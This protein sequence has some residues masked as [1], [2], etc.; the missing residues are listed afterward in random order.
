MEERRRR[1]NLVGPTILV[2]IGIVLLLN[3]LGWTA[4]S[5]WDLLRLWPI[6]LIAGGLEL[7]IGQRSRLGSVLVLLVMLGMLAGGLWLLGSWWPLSSAERT[8]VSEPLGGATNAEIEVDFGVGTLAMGSMPESGDLV[9]GTVELHRGEQLVREASTAGNTAYVALRSKGNWSVPVFGWEGDKRWVLQI[10]RD[11]PVKLTTSA[12]VGD[13][14]LDLKSL[15][16]SEL[17]LDMGIG[18][19]TVLLP[20]RGDLDARIETGIGELIVKVPQGAGVRVQAS[21]G[22]GNVSVPTGY[23]RQDDAYVSSGY[24]SADSRIDLV[25]EAGIGRILVQEHRGE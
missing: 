2:V 23:R 14:S 19:A 5:V 6:L 21:T 13:V 17:G 10:N 20:A 18:R 11:V 24:A 4:I 9:Q 15:R 7:L 1:V 3:N 25:L 12:G 16:L 8:E 22:L